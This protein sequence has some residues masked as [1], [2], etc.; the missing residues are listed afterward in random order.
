MGWHVASLVVRCRP[1]LEAGL[2][3]QLRTLPASEV[4]G[5]QDGRIVVLV[6][7]VNEYALADAFDA[8]RALPHVLGADLVHHEI[9]SEDS[10]AEHVQ[11]AP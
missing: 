6:E 11:H 2:V 8:I 10:E 7:G 4:R 9:D 1:G 3:A 5:A